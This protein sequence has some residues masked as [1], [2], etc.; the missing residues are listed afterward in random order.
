MRK[1]EQIIRLIGNPPKGG[2]LP[3]PI[4]LEIRQREIGLLEFQWWKIN[5]HRHGRHRQALG[6]GCNLSFEIGDGAW[7]PFRFRHSPSYGSLLVS[8]STFFGQSRHVLA[9]KSFFFRA[10]LFFAIKAA[11]ILLEIRKG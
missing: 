6:G 9:P 7:R 2:A 8:N 3:Q 5:P 11:L 10:L 4:V 1:A